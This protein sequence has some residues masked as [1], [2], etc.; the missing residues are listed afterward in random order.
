MI[1]GFI[2][3]VL[4]LLGIYGFYND[5]Y[6]LTYIAFVFCLFENILGRLDGSLKTIIPF[7]LFCI[8]GV[9]FTKDLW[10]GLSI[11]ACFENS[12]FFV[13]GI[14]FMIFVYFT[15]KNNREL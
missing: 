12:I 7:L 13:I 11:G 4:S 1:L 2:C 14:F 3:F 8:L 5:V 9:I 6:I 10:L 15:S